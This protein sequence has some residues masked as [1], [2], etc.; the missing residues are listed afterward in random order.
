MN[1]SFKFMRVKDDGRNEELTLQMM[2]N[3]HFK[4][5]IALILTDKN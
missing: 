1:I 4:G 3:L 5:L 2:I